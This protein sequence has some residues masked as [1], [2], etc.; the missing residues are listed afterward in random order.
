MLWYINTITM[1][2]TL[3]F[4][5]IYFQLL[6]VSFVMG[7]DD[8]SEMKHRCKNFI[9]NYV[10]PCVKR[11]VCILLFDNL[12][13]YN[14]TNTF[15]LCKLLYVQVKFLYKHLMQLRNRKSFNVAGFCYAIRIVESPFK[16]MAWYASKYGN[17]SWDFAA[18]YTWF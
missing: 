15:N 12:V 17:I 8:S 10:I 7:Y 1:L 2:V 9:P 5:W 3:K 6:T 11:Y 14:M 16:D 13:R 18:L 4:V